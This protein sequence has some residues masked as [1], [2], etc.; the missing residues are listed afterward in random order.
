[1]KANETIDSFLSDKWQ[2]I[3]S[4]Q[5]YRFSVDA[6]LLAEFVSI[7]SNDVVVDLGA[8]CGIIS[9]ILAVKRKVGF[10]VGLELQEELASQAQRNIA[11]NKLVKK[12]GI[13]RGDL[14]HLPIGPEFAHVVVCNPPYRR[15][16][17]GRINPDFSKAIARHELSTKLDD[18]LTAGKALLKPGGRLSLIYPANRLT[19]IFAK[20]R[21]QGV[22][23]KRLQIVFPNSYSN[24]K[25]VMI[26]GKLQ[27][28]SGLK[29]L[30]PLFGQGGS[31]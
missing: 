2:I 1:M 20:M 17:S 19:E 3:Q 29:I 26:E 9:L 22:E 28:K 27:G 12:I 24:A 25:L 8:G 7:R 11:L 15:Q 10:I 23:P 6:L 30:P 21:I 18:I 4:R 16:K 13:I 5:G 31:Q 14:R